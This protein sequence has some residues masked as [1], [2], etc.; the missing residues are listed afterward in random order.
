MSSMDTQDNA[1][2]ASV[3][4][5]LPDLEET[6][7]KNAFENLSSILQSDSPEELK[8]HLKSWCCLIWRMLVASLLFGRFLP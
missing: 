8:Q 2:L 6:E 1:Q 4:S 5:V 7:I 3:A